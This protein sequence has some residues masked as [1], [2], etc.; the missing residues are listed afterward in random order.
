[1]NIATQRNPR[2]YW[3]A[4]LVGQ[5]L[6]TVLYLLVGSI[7]YVYAGICECLLHTF[8]FAGSSAHSSALAQMSPLRHSGPPDPC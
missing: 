2:D 7:V 8:G 1:M 3:K 4:A 6:A 5:I